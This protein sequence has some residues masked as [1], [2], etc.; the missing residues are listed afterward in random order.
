MPTTTSH[1]DGGAGVARPTLRLAVNGTEHVLDIAA[2]TPLVYV[3]RN[4]LR[5]NGPKFGC[6]L[7]E[8]GACTVLVDGVAAR[9]LRGGGR[10]RPGPRGNHAGGTGLR[11]GAAPGA[12]CLHRGAGGAVRLL[13]QRH[14]HRHHGAARPQSDPPR[15][16]CGRLCA[17]TCA[18]AAPMWRSCA[19]SSGPPRHDGDPPPG[20]CC[21]STPCWT[22]PTAFWCCAAAEPTRRLFVAVAADGTVTALQRACRPRHRHPHRAGA[23]RRRG[24]GRRARPGTHGAGRHGAR[25]E[26]GRDHRQRDHPGHRRA[27]AR[28]RRARR[29]A[30]CWP[31][32]GA[33]W[34]RRRPTSRRGRDRAPA[35]HNRHVTL[36]RVAG[37]ASATGWR[38]T[39]GAGASR[40]PS[41]AWSASR[42][43][44][45]TSRPRPRARSPTCTTC[46]CPACCMAASCGRPM[47]A[48][49]AARSSG[50]PGRGGRGL[51]RHV[52]G[53]VAVVVIGDFVGVVAEREEHAVQ[54]ARRCGSPGAGRLRCPT[55]TSR[56][57]AAG[58][59]G[60]AAH[61]AGPRATW[62]PRSR[63]PR[64]RCAG[65]MS[66]RTRCTARSAR[67]ARSRTGPGRR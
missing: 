33:S 60:H 61:P 18:A 27:A 21:R 15:T 42:C 7:G 58:Q 16:R 50:Q 36:R 67:P 49:I 26:P 9:V 46:A 19:P 30:S 8:C 41:T 22:R 3:L 48:S 44:G 55:S 25:A 14:D 32:G 24:A 4:D 20:R 37:A 34:A 52:P 45:W 54:A 65:P 29:G 1:G 64:R 5:L 11:H 10:C 31:G 13:P 53:L 38:W 43:R 56:G 40:W 47:P 28:G 66:G 59:P 23:D 57:G 35:R 6:G 2:S 39:S 51:G 62:M 17:T 63:A 12:A